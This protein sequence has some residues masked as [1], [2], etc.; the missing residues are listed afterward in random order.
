MEDRRA[1]WE[2]GAPGP[3]PQLTQKPSL[4]SSRSGGR[5]AAERNHGHVKL[6]EHSSQD[7]VPRLFLGPGQAD[8]GL[9][10]IFFKKEPQSFPQGNTAAD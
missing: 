4:F 1:G 6:R 2:Q 8:Q 3:P 7:L 5:G 10:S 9:R